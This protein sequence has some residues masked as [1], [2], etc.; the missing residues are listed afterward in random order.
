MPRVADP[1]R[2]AGIESA[3]EH[4]QIPP[5]A[6][7]AHAHSA[8]T[9]SSLSK[10]SRMSTSSSTPL[11]PHSI[12]DL[13]AGSVPVVRGGCAGE[14]LSPSGYAGDRDSSPSPSSASFTTS[15]SL[16]T[17]RSTPTPR[18]P[19]LSFFSVSPEPDM[20]QVSERYRRRLAL[21]EVEVDSDHLG[22]DSGPKR[23]E[24]DKLRS[25]LLS[26]EER[27]G[28]GVEVYRCA[29]TDCCSGRRGNDGR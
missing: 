24:K 7:S 13:R 27:K 15:S 9:S 14:H 26:R 19:G 6:Q 2:G 5:G 17:A 20:E 28:K 4:P 3:T 23:R 21:Y 12:P 29:D 8:S 10:A 22:V 1:S 25:R 18:T 11:T 16:G